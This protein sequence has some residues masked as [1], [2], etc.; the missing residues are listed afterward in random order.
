MSAHISALELVY[1]LITLDFLIM[2]L[3]AIFELRVGRRKYE[4]WF[5][6]RE[7]CP[8]G[9]FRHSQG[10]KCTPVGIF[11]FSCFGR[12]YEGSKFSKMAAD[13]EMR[14]DVCNSV[15]NAPLFTKLHKM[16]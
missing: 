10:A 16:T 13:M 8:R 2:L 9:V 15:A 14:L 6:I 4:I 12:N 7:M 5:C 1:S 11:C 3:F